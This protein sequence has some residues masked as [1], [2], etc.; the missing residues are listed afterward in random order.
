M[1]VFNIC[2]DC[3]QL[4][5]TTYK[6]KCDCIE[7]QEVIYR[8]MLERNTTS[9]N[10]QDVQSFQNNQNN[11]SEENLCSDIKNEID[12]EDIRVDIKTIT[13]QEDLHIPFNYGKYNK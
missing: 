3:A 4:L 5:S 7:I 2:K 12:V 8:Y 10:L 11:N 1:P 13:K 9:L 6:F